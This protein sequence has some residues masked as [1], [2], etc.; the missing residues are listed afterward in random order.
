MHYLLVGNYGTGNFGDEALKEYFLSAFPEAKFRVLSAHPKEGELPRLPAGIRSFFLAHWWRTL[1]ALWKS[2]G[3][4]FGGGTLFTDTESV[5]ACLLWWWHAFVCWLLGKPFFLA[6]QGIGPFRTRAGEWFA[7]WA[8]AHAAFVSV[9]DAASFQRVNLWRKNTNIIQTCDPVFSLFTAQKR[10]TSSQKLLVIIPRKNSPSSFSERA[11][12]LWKSGTWQAVR[13]LSLQPDDPQER[14]VCHSIA[15]VLSQPDSVIV[16]VRSVGALCRSVGQADFVFS[17]R[18]HGALAA[19]AL[20]V[21]FEV[22][23]QGEG[24]KLAS[25][26]GMSS[27]G[28]A[29]LLADGERQLKSALF[30]ELRVSAKIQS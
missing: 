6:F 28:I 27:S 20:G 11:V 12:Q 8:I 13:I 3:L 23:P 4:V 14:E 30:P 19:L 21:P 1:A 2:D 22:V 9:R 5:Y 29:A 15:H 26:S 7:R 16:P 17:Q 25:L 18:Y 10:D 24:D